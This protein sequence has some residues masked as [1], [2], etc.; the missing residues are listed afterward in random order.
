MLGNWKRAVAGA[1]AGLAAAVAVPVIAQVSWLATLNSPA[2]EAPLASPNIA[3]TSDGAIISAGIV[4]AG[5][6]VRVRIARMSSAGAV[7]WVR[8]AG[9][10]GTLATPTPL[11]AH[12][13]GSVT[14]AYGDA[15]MMYWCFENFSASGDSRY[16]KCVT[17][18]YQWSGDFRVTLA[19][20]GDFYFAFG[21]GQ[22]TVRKV[23]PLGT[24]RWTHSETSGSLPAPSVQ[25]VDSAGNYF[26]AAGTRLVAWN[27]V[28]GSKISDVSLAGSGVALASAVA[29]PR[30]TR[31]VVMLRAQ[32]ATANA[33]TATVTR[34]SA[35]GAV[36]WSRDLIFPGYG[37]YDKL[38]LVGADG[39]ATY[40]LRTA[41]VDGD[42]HVA[43]ISAT[44]VLLWQKHYARVRRIIAYGPTLTAVRSDVS[45]IS[46]SNDSFL[47]PVAA[48]DGALGTPMIYSR[49]DVF[50]PTD[51]FPTATG[52]MAA[53][54][55]ANPFAPFTGFPLAVAAT[56]TFI[57]FDTPSNRWQV[58]STVR[59]VSSAQQ[60]DC[61]MPRLAQSSPTA[62]WA[63]TQ[64]AASSPNMAIWYGRDAATGAARGQSAPAAYGCGS[65]L[66]PDGGQVVVSSTPADR[67]KKF[68][69]AGSLVWQSPSALFPT[70][71]NGVSL[72]STAPTGEVTFV[73]GSLL[74][75]VTSS[76][77][78]AF[79][80]ETN[81]NNARYLAVDSANNAWVVSGYYGNDTYVSKVSAAGVL[82]WS[83][84]VDVPACSDV[85]MSAKLTA[86]DE[87]LVATQSCNEGRVFKLNGSGQIVWQRLVSGTAQRPSVLLGTLQVDAAG[88]I[89][90]G[91][92]VANG[93]PTS[94]GTNG[95]SLLASWTSTG[96]ERWTAATD[97]IAAG[98]EC[99]TSIAVDGT[100]NVF[101]TSSSSDASRGPV[102][103]ALNASGGER[104]RHQGVLAN[105]FASSTE[106]ALDATGKIIAL[107]EAPPGAMGDREANL[108]RID[109]ALLGSSLRL[110]ILQV[111]TPAANYRTP[112]TVRIGLRT[113]ADAPAA[114]TTETMVSLGILAG[115]GNLS[116]TLGCTIAVGSSEC[117]VSD[118][119][120]DAVET[121]VT[122]IASADGYAAV[123]SS[124][125]SVT[126]AATSLALTASSVGPFPAF[127]L[128]P[129]RAALQ[130]PLPPSG[131]N[132]GSIGGP[133][134]ASGTAYNC[135]YINASGALPE[136]V[137][138]FLAQAASSPVNAYF[139]PYTNVYLASVATPL[140]LQIT[141]VK[142]T[143]QVVLDPINTFVAGDKIRLRVSMTVP[144]GFNVSAFVAAS[145]ISISGGTCTSVVAVG[146]VNTL[147]AGNYWNCEIAAAALGSQSVSVSFAGSNDLLAA[148]PVT[149]AVTANAGSVVRGTTYIPPGT[150][151]C[152]T[153]PG[154]TCATMADGYGWQCAGPVAADMD[155][156]FL[157]GNTPYV[158]PNTPLKFKNVTGLLSY[159]NGPFYSFSPSTC[160]LDVDGDGARMAITDG[161][162]ILRRMLGLSGTALTVGA[163]HA[164]VPRTAAA[165]AGGIS[166]PYYDV[167]GDGQTL[168]A[169]D[170]LILLRA[171]L[172]FRGDA[173]IAGATG[174]NA[175]RK[176][177][178]DVQSFLAGNCYFQIN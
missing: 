81:R 52:V 69:S 149:L 75:R 156:F 38:R 42:S 40:V 107:G 96:N 12:P 118:T 70:Y 66:T 78:L 135:T 53:Y 155:V 151:V 132:P 177:Y 2:V 3:Q 146:S 176:T 15:S 109:P 24:V 13:D 153:A 21:S 129:V 172:G 163:T 124:P 108:R 154:V 50:A 6:T 148:D 133:Y 45:A 161:V 97:L 20:D 95:L 64:L 4:I 143:L 28:D 114:A 1:L 77:A 126:A 8:W 36:V 112:F 25:G 35:T 88:N 127:T 125:F 51:W 7:H 169:T 26:E 131:L 74:G 39:D 142:P 175:T 158:Y 18:A 140:T 90:A 48:A 103:W 19:A 174:A 165:I 136:T 43:K 87:M 119:N 94:S 29:L 168:P 10:G 46:S 47:F 115:Y 73:T 58:T 93:T 62:W 170:G 68:N 166:L 22:R 100:G 147:F 9:A 65:P 160:S 167:D 86:A 57:G 85:L 113:D 120:Y 79:E 152:S 105:P 32:N 173:L 138:D 139:T 59:P 14:V 41:D 54:Q 92:C 23:S 37:P 101:A 144:N 178:A 63:R 102:L 33:M 137:C 71:T 141:K 31:D 55:G 49:A 76:G 117:T 110:K 89:Y 122:L 5:P 44:G 159:G 128:V 83:V 164:C 60:G 171:L 56:T 34:S 11:W 157:P 80:I 130:A 162:L 99:V 111:P 30:A 67:A 82:Q 84:P 104:W 98:A 17:D 72:L 27:S 61:L 106:I 134:A 145:S 123:T 16:R 121:G 91:G 150:T 116:G